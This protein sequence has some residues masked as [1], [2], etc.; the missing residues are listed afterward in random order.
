MAYFGWQFSKG[1]ALDAVWSWPTTHTINQFLPVDQITWHGP[2]MKDG[3]CEL[4]KMAQFHHTTQKH[5]C[6]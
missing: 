6:T 2:D 3:Q 5:Y 4:I 1:L